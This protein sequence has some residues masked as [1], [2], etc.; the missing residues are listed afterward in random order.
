M[1]GL[2]RLRLGGATPSD[3]RSLPDFAT[4]AGSPGSTE[5][6]DRRRQRQREER[7]LPHRVQAWQPVS[8]QYNPR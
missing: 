4:M 1:D 5:P 3:P 8:H 6:L 2:Q 7:S